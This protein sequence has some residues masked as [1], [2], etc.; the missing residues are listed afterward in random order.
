MLIDERS[1]RARMTETG[2]Q[3]LEACTS[4]GGERAPTCIRSWKCSSG[5][6][7][8]ARAAF[9]I[10]RKLDRR[11]GAPFGPTKTR[12]RS[13]GSAKRS[14]CQR[15]SGT[16]SSGEGD[17][18]ATSSRF[19]CLWQK[20]AL[21]KAVPAAPQ[22]RGLRA[23]QRLRTPARRTPGH[24]CT[25]RRCRQPGDDCGGGQQHWGHQASQS[26]SQVKPRRF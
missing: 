20:A 21:V 4:G 10:G 25:A 18:A 24:A 16:S 9:Q 14:R 17:R 26:K 8:L 13:P 6:P 22:A 5:V 23:A 7:A 12:P 15:S 3:L 11:N 2:H 19:R 1:S